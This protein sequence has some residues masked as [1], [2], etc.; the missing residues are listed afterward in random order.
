MRPIFHNVYVRV[1]MNAIMPYTGVNF[2]NIGY[3]L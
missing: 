3:S 2:I 1:L